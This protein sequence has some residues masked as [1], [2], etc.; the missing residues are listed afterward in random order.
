MVSAAQI[1]A[2]YKVGDTIK[3]QLME[4]DKEGRLNFKKAA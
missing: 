1:H 4:K 2:T 3:V